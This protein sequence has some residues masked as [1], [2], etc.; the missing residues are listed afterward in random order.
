MQVCVPSW[1]IVGVEL[2]RLLNTA[3]NEARRI[4]IQESLDML[5]KKNTTE[6]EKSQQGT[7]S[8]SVYNKVM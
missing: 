5:D 4:S 2:L 8:A 1:M 3:T 6:E 7:Y